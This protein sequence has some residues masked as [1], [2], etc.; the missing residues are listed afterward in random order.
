MNK[1]LI[2]LC[3]VCSCLSCNTID[4][5]KR[6]PVNTE[7]ISNTSNVNS[8][9]QLLFISDRDGQENFYLIN[10]EGTDLIKLTNYQ[11]ISIIED[12]T[13][14][15]IIITAC[16]NGSPI[17]NIYRL[18]ENGDIVQL[19]DNTTYHIVHNLS[20]DR[21]KITYYDDSQAI[22]LMNVDGTDKTKVFQA[23]CG[24]PYW[25]PDSKS[26]VTNDGYNNIY[27]WSADT[28]TIRLGAGE[29]IESTDMWSP[30]SRGIIIQ[31]KKYNSSKKEDDYLSI[32]FI[33]IDTKTSVIL[34]RENYK[35]L[36]WLSDDMIA[37]AKNNVIYTASLGSFSL[38]TLLL[39]D[40]PIVRTNWSSNNLFCVAECKGATDLLYL[41]FDNLGQ[42]QESGKIS[43][44]K[45]LNSSYIYDQWSQD[46]LKYSYFTQAGKNK[47]IN[48]FNFSNKQVQTQIIGEYNTLGEGNWS[49]DNIHFTFTAGNWYE[50]GHNRN[51]CDIF[52]FDI[53][54]NQL[55]NVTNSSSWDCC[56]TFIE[57]KQV[58]NPIFQPTNSGVKSTHPSNI[59]ILQSITVTPA[60]PQPLHVGYVQEFEAT[61]KYSDGSIRDITSEVNWASSN[62]SVAWMYPYGGAFAK[63]EGTCQITATIDSIVSP[64]VVMMVPSNKTP[65]LIYLD[66]NYSKLWDS[67]NVPD[68]NDIYWK[69][70]LS[71]NRSPYNWEEGV[72]TVYLSNTGTK[73]LR[74]NA[75]INLR[76]AK[77]GFSVKSE[78]V[79]IPPNGR[80]SL[81]I[82]VSRSSAVLFKTTGSFAV[83]F[84][85]RTLTEQWLVNYLIG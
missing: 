46:S 19:A 20:P 23:G 12:Y 10:E 25:S 81:N 68:L 47:Y 63:S 1:L 13:L 51:K 80:T 72:L 83:W 61:G 48:F 28:N 77:P 8:D 40:G 65:L 75:E 71:D 64:K 21:M 57:Y 22:Y 42:L 37:I 52:I 32:K 67:T 18:Y 6:Y 50:K 36:H 15:P 29:L 74:V 58:E 27:L 9:K 16:V 26:M 33:D 44:S 59:I 54:N 85:I 84:N 34:A 11:N 53:S 60:S 38:R 49:K 30:D 39:A 70:D 45:D 35:F 43:N 5:Q 2:V 14:E 79:T 73:T 17:P 76:A 62:E 41:I 55:T 66:A 31:D 24:P 69:T 78:T 7:N 3:L 56:S 82:T 4:I